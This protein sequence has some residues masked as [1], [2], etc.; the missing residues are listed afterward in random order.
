VINPIVYQETENVDFIEHIDCKE[1]LPTDPANKGAVGGPLDPS[2]VRTVFAQERF[3]ELVG[4]LVR[5]AFKGSILSLACHAGHHRSYTAA[6]TTT[7]ILNLLVQG[8]S[9]D[10]IS[11]RICNAMHFP[12]TKRMGIPEAKEQISSAKAWNQQPWLLSH[13]QEVYGK[14]SC[15]LN[16]QSW[17]SW[18]MIEGDVRHMQKYYKEQIEDETYEPPNKKTRQQPEAS[19]HGTSSAGASQAELG[20]AWKEAAGDADGDGADEAVMQSVGAPEQPDG[21]GP[22]DETD[23]AARAPE[24]SKAWQPT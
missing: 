6:V 1:W 10:G 18:K 21:A 23:E 13:A 15:A 11:Q 7:S 3:P 4:F 9:D 24:A 8:K 12:L 5:Q 19:M 20:Q 2:T 17:K 22:R 16:P 14:V